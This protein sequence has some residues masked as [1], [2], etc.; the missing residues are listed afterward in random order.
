MVLMFLCISCSNKFTGQMT[1][2]GE[3]WIIKEHVH[4]RIEKRFNKCGW[5]KKCYTTKKF[6][7]GDLEYN[8]LCS[9]YGKVNVDSELVRYR[10]ADQNRYRRLWG[11]TRGSDTGKVKGYNTKIYKVTINTTDYDI[12]QPGK[13]NNINSVQSLTSTTVNYY[14]AYKIC[15]PPMGSCQ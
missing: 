6:E 15:P 4:N 10:H 8:Y 3:G 2:P 5:L 9:T 11:L 14:Y 1:Q 7:Q 12:K 13:K